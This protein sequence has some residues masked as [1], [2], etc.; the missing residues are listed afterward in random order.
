MTVLDAAPVSSDPASIVHPSPL[1]V[2]RS[3]LLGDLPSV[4]HGVTRRVAGMGRADGNLGYSGDRD[5]DDAWRMRRHW[6]AAVG[7]DPELLAVAGQIHG[8]DVLRVGAADAGRGA[9]PDS[10]RAGIADA[11]IT[12]ESGVA[13]LS[14]HADCLPVLLVDPDRPA[15]GVA[16]AGWRGTVADVAGAAVRAMNEAYGSRP[17]ALRAFLGPAI[18]PCCYEVGT[19]VA[20]AWRVQ[21]G[22]AVAPA[23]S[24]SAERTLFDLRRGNAHLLQRAGLLPQHIDHSDICTRCAS[25]DWFTHRGQGPS[26]GRF[27]AI[28]ALGRA[29]NRDERDVS[30]SR[31]EG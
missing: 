27:G 6:A 17:S 23:L 25:G 7:V 19:D 31:A 10:P 18:G 21:A 15:V 16:H 5:R 29:D 9:R 28:I 26:T 12:D 20:S 1:L 14:L 2:L 13:L 8:A 11:L 30:P 22:G 24:A 4:V 3:R